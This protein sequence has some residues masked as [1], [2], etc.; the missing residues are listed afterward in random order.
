V[1]FLTEQ[2]EAVNTAALDTFG[3]P[4]TVDGTSVTGDF[5]QPWE[6]GFLGGVSAAASGPQLVLVDDD[7]PADPVGKTVTA[8]GL[9]FT[10][11]E[12]RPDGYGLTLLLLEAA[13]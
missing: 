2:I 13:A 4:V 7:V 5:A 6:Q 1:S 10:I 12:A 8:R 9:N 3:E 11:A